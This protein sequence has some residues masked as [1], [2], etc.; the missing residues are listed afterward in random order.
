MT[1]ETSMASKTYRKLTNLTNDR[2]HKIA[3]LIY[4]SKYIKDLD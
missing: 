4:R 2:I 1:I 3:H